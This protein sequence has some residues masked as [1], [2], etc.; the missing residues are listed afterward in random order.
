[1]SVKQ[2]RNVRFLDDKGQITQEWLRYLDSLANA[3]AT[4]A[5]TGSKIIRNW[6]PHDASFPASNYATLDTRNTHPVLDF[7]TTTQETVYFH[8]VMPDNYDAEGITIEL[9][10]TATSAT[11]GTIGWDVSL[12]QM[13]GLDVDGDSFATAQTVTAATVSATNG[14]LQS[15]SVSI[16]DGTAMD[17]LVAGDMFRLRVRRNVSA[18]TATGD[19]E[20]HMVEMRIQ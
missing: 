8:G 14:T 9:W 17:S 16:A 13:D 1:M 2:P 10:W 18:D 20:L 5:A 6:G 11:S 3:A 7:D 15:S 19:A 12:E 4:A